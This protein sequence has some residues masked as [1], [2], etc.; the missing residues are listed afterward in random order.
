[1]AR[2]QVA[3]YATLFRPTSPY[4]AQRSFSIQ[5]LNAVSIV[6]RKSRVG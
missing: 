1:M 3:E 2:R 4:L 6:T 5:A